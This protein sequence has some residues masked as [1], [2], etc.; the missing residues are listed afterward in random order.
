M[1]LPFVARTMRIAAP[2]QLVLGQLLG[3][4]GTVWQQIYLEQRLT[5]LI[6]HMLIRSALALACY[7]AVLGMSRGALQA[8]ASAIKLPMLYLLTLA[9][10]LPT[11]YL[12]NLLGG[13]RLS[14]RQ[15]LAL[16]L[17]AISVTALL[18]LPFAPVALFFLVTLDNYYFYKLFNVALLALTSGI[19]LFMLVDGAQELNRSARQQF[20]ASADSDTTLAK[21]QIMRPVSTAL[22]PVW[23]LLYSFV[24]TQL[25]WTLRPFFGNPD[26]SFQLFRSGGGNFYV[27][28]LETIVQ[29]LQ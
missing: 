15:A 4:R 28:V 7:G 1:N 16:V 14:P 20:E 25:A 21:Q 12:F 27:G 24:G 11:L 17:A 22:L 19:G 6:Q 29:L 2:P 18:L 23:L 5:P 8:L 10:C 3:N 13:G 26:V 9:V